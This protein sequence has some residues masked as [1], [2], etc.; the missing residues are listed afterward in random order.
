MAGVLGDVVTRPVTVTGDPAEAILRERD[1]D[2]YLTLINPNLKN[3]SRLT[4]HLTERFT[5]AV[6]RGVE[7]G[8][9]VPLRDEG[10]GSTFD[11]T[12]AP[13]EGT[14]VALSR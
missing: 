11:L 7:R 6:D 1:E 3:P 14:V 13:G 9:A 10:E 5:R 4:I 2:Q 12:L 8:F